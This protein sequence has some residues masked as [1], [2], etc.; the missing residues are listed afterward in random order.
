MKTIA[1][2]QSRFAQN[3]V[4]ALQWPT[5]SFYS[6]SCELK[7]TSGCGSGLMITEMQGVYMLVDRVDF[8]ILMEIDDSSD[9]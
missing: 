8:T 9:T 1:I 6:F 7:S 4:K 2:S 5:T 3:Q